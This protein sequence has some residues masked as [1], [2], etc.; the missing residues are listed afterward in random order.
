MRAQFGS[1]ARSQP[2]LLNN[3]LGH[4][5]SRIAVA[6]DGL[7]DGPIGGTAPQ[8]F[9]NESDEAGLSKRCRLH[10]L[11]KGGMRR[12]AESGGTAHELMAISGHKTLSEVQRYTAD[13]DRKKLADSGMNKKRGGESQN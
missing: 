8:K 9:P 6:N 10:G 3:P 5:R 11:K 2:P 12:L 7:I 1:A 13:A 4:L